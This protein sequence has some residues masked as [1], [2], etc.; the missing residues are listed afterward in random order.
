MGD[1]DG[2]L[3]RGADAE[4]LISF[5]PGFFSEPFSKRDGSLFLPEISKS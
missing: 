4:V 2:F 3:S 5:G 1:Q